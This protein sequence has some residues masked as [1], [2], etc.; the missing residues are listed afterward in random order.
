MQIFRIFLQSK[1]SARFVTF[2][3]S[4]NRKPY[5]LNFNISIALR[6]Y[7]HSQ[8]SDFR[9]YFPY[10]HLPSFLNLNQYPDGF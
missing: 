4:K 7:K 9:A 5:I 10:S 1:D 2:T 6:A 3:D 8:R